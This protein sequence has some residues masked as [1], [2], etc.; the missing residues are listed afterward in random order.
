MPKDMSRDYSLTGAASDVEF[1]IAQWYA[2]PVP[3]KRLKELMRRSDKPGLVNYGSWLLLLLGSGAL[4]VAV[5]GTPW[6]W[7]VA[8]VYGLL[9]GSGGDSRWHETGHGTVFRTRWLND[10]FY[11]LCSFTSLRNPHLW[12]WSHT[13]HHSETVIVGRDPEIAFPRPPSLREWAMNLLYVPA[14]MKELGRMVR[15][16]S[17]RVNEAEASYLPER[18]R[19]KAYLV[20][21]IHLGILL[22]AVV[23]SLTAGSWLPLMLV[24]LPTF[25]GTWLHHIMAT[26]QHAGL[27][28][29][30]PDHRMNS[31]TVY[32][33]PLFRFIYSN[34]N[35][36][37]EHHMYPMVPYYNL[38]ALH[39]EIRGDCPPAYPSLWAC[40]RE[41]LPAVLRQQ[42]DPNHYIRRPL[43]EGAGP[44]PDYVRPVISEG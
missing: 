44:T 42:R 31:R 30:V 6:A 43:P 15:L 13:R 18:E 8:L 20:A 14:V 35:Y 23:A 36:H 9:Y 1:D 16:A 3:R 39:A 37:V 4:L 26:T 32:L 19:P 34:M 11:Q 28:E 21:R 40:Y 24:G 29:D 17:G 25:Y 22:A 27:A 12:R 33:N 2:S 10:A 5:W 41:M 7:P 38:P